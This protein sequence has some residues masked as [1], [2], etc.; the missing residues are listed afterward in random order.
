MEQ[1]E[2][3]VKR[4]FLERT[5][6]VSEGLFWWVATSVLLIIGYAFIELFL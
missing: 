3:K 2:L 6:A 1:E 5:L 4:P